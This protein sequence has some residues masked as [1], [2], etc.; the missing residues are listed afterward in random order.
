MSIQNDWMGYKIMFESGS[1]IRGVMRLEDVKKFNDGKCSFVSF[2]RMDGQWLDVNLA[3][4]NA[5]FIEDIFQGLNEECVHIQNS[6]EA[7]RW[8]EKNQAQRDNRA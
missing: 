7:Q 8:F 6:Q 5:I 3:H 4:V 2:L 1:Q